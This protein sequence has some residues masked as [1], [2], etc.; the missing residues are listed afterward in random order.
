[1]FPSFLAVMTGGA[2]GC[3]LRWWMGLRF[4]GVLA[5]MPLGTLLVNLIGGFIIG[6]ALAFFARMPQLDSAWKLLITTGFC[7]GLTTFSTFSSEVVAMLQEG[8][9]GW[10]VGTIAAHLAGSLLMTYVGITLVNVIWQ[11]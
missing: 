7:G 4:N 2:A 10:A 1:M 6:V 9:P 5:A 3:V 11:E 8:R